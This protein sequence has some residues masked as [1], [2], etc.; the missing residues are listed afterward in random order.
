MNAH[1]REGYQRVD[2]R[3]SMGTERL[4][5][6]RSVQGGHRLLQ[7]EQEEDRRDQRQDRT[8]EPQL[9]RG[10]AGIRIHTYIH[11]ILKLVKS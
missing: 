9:R 2:N 11:L 6:Q 3:S 8:V 7:Q 10:R 5:W 4:E 1:S